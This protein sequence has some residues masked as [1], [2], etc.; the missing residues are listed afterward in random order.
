MGLLKG[1]IDIAPCTVEV[2]HV[3]EELSAHVRLDDGSVIHPGDSVTVSGAPVIAG[4]GES[5]TERRTATIRR[6]GPLRR[7]WTRLT[8]DL[9]FMEL[10]EFS[11]SEDLKLEDAA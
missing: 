8:G 6:A 1:Q 3:F 5:V 2:V 7:A 9:E 11:F 4:Y 10:C